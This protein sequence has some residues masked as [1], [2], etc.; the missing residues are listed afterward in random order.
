MATHNEPSAERAVDPTPQDSRARLRPTRWAAPAAVAVS[1]VG[2]WVYLAVLAV[3]GVRPHTSLTGL[4]YALLGCWLWALVWRRRARIGDPFR[5]SRLAQVYAGATG[6]LFV[7]FV[8]DAGL[9]VHSSFSLRL[10]AQLVLWTAPTAVLFLAMARDELERAL[11]A[12]AALGTAFAVLELAMTWRGSVGGR[13]SPLAH[14]DPISAAQY[15]A[16]ALLALLS[17]RP[18]P[19][20][21]PAYVCAAML[22]VFGALLPGSRGPVAG[23]ILG[24]VATLLLQGGDARRRAALAAVLAATAVGGFAAASALGSSGHLTP[25]VF[26]SKPKS[27]PQQAP[28]KHR[29]PAVSSDSVRTALLSQALHRARRR[30]LLGNGVGT[31]AD[32]SAVAKRIGLNGCCT[33]PHNEPVEALYS[34]GIG[35][36]VLYVVAIASAIVAWLRLLRLAVVGRRG[37]AVVVFAVAFAIYAFVQS[38]VSGEIGEDVWIWASASLVFAAA[39]VAGEPR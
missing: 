30:L 28:P 9:R 16:I 24:A 8:V 12:V 6:L 10:A 25:A 22:L 15:A 17:L 26:Q 5:A 23:M 14:L 4:Y 39:T 36:L 7:W 35:G 32:E 34:L 21:T 29:E 19:R 18:S 38:E 2:F 33:Y 13:Y 20:W 11:L 3:V 27:H 1:L 37:I 31:L